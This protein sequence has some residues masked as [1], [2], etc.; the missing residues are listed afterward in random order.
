MPDR[1]KIRLKGPWWGSHCSTEDGP[2]ASMHATDKAFKTTIPFRW[3][4]QIPN[5]FI[6][7]V[8]MSRKFNCS[9]GMSEAREVWLTI[10]SLDAP[11]EL[12]LNG[13]TI[14]V[15]KAQTDIQISVSSYL[16]SFNELQILLSVSG[17]PP[18][19]LLGDV[20]VEI[21]A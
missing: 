11:A 19:I 12:F 6:G 14:G 21:V 9:A 3:H 13:K 17:I 15:F 10:S 1:H 7:T 20:A 2:N 5:D 18:E 8:R 16:T 4:D